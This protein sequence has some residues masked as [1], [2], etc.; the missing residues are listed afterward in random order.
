ML[1]WKLAAR[2]STLYACFVHETAYAA[3]EA[4]MSRFIDCIDFIVYFIHCHAMSRITLLQWVATT[5]TVVP[6]VVYDMSHVPLFHCD[7]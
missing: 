7:L 5:V 1:H 3:D 6:S 2:L 4:A